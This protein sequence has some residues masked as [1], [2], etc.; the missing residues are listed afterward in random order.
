[1]PSKHNFFKYFYA[2]AKILVIL[3]DIAEMLYMCK[4]SNCSNIRYIFSEM[5]A[6]VHISPWDIYLYGLY[7]DIDEIIKGRCLAG[8]CRDILVHNVIENEWT[9]G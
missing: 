7:I 4:S 2:G 9:R 6:G 5:K 3:S 8:I 1:M